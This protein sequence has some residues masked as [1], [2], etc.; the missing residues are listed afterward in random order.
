MTFKKLN[1]FLTGQYLNFY[2][3]GKIAELFGLSDGGDAARQ[4]SQLQSAS[5]DKAIDLTRESRDIARKDLQPFTEAGTKT[6]PGLTSLIEDPNAKKA[7]VENN[8]FFK[9]QADESQRRLFNNQ[10]ARGK[11]GSGGTAEA[12]QNSLLLL[13]NDLVNENIGQRFNLASLGQSSAA[14]QA[15]ITQSA[16]AQG[17]NLLTQQGNVQASGVIGAENARV[18][19]INSLLNLAA[20]AAGGGF[21]EFGGTGG[22]TGFNASNAMIGICW[23]ARE[24]YGEDNPKWLLFREWLVSKAPKWFFNLYK[25]HGEAFAKWVHNKPILKSIIRKWMDNKVGI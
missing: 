12:L 11:V 2:F 21:G 22:K 8:P 16:G 13:G 1:Y 10:A 23:V 17:S 3:L 6:L 24:V 14:G 19:G 4:A 15:N 25:D 9:A 18:G 20:T 5:A 7:F